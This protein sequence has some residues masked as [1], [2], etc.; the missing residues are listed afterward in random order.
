MNLKKTSI[1]K[2]P[3]YGPYSTCV[4]SG[5][6]L[7]ISGQI[8]ENIEESSSIERETKEIMKNIEIILKKNKIDFT[9]IVKATIF[10]KNINDFSKINKIYSQ[11]FIKD[12]YPARETVQVSGLPKNANI[13]IS[14]IGFIE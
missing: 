11:F 7:F 10:V 6:F 5:N 13:E 1:K 4:L 12:N 3:C 8:A 14:M 9:N 2:I